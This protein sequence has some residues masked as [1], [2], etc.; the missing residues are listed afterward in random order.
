MGVVQSSEED[1]ATNTAAPKP[2]GSGVPATATGSQPAAAMTPAATAA[3]GS[4]TTQPGK[5]SS[6]SST[7]GP[8]SVPLVIQVREVS[9]LTPPQ[10]GNL[11]RFLARMEPLQWPEP[12]CPSVG[13]SLKLQLLLRTHRQLFG[14]GQATATGGSTDGSVPQ[15]LRAWAQAGGGANAAGGAAMTQRPKLQGPRADKV[16][17]RTFN[18]NCLHLF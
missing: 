1:A 6:R 7:S 17:R 9:L 15:G 5:S 16:R 2:E 18:R 8:A 14:Y 13:A 4:G 12:Q 3:A 11:A 10:Q